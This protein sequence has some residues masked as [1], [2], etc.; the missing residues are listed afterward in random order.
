[1]AQAR[2]VSSRP[3]G[4]AV[5]PSIDAVVARMRPTDPLL[6]LRPAAIAGA[7]RRFVDCFPGD[8]LY[9]VK[10][11]PEP[12]VLRALWAGGI[13]HFDCASLAEVALVRKLLPAAEVHFMHPVKSRPAIRDAFDA[14][15]RDRFRVRQRRRA[16]EDPAGDGAGRA[17]RRSAD[18]GAVRAARLAEGRRGLRPVRQVRR[19]ARRGGRAAARGAAARRSSRHRLPCRLAVPR[20]GGLCAGNG[21]GRRGDRTLRGCRSTSSMSA[22]ASR[23][24]T[25]T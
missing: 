3:L 11:N 21:A 2:L 22:A 24:A 15:W 6:C 14:L 10:C 23:S 13:R 20:A 4:R 18:V 9:A 1:M 19:A 12:R 7:A 17:G 25:P 8:V 16:G 5:F